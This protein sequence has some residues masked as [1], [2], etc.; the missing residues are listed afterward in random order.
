MSMKMRLEV[1]RVDTVG[2]NTANLCVAEVQL[3]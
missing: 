2:H 3:P 1:K